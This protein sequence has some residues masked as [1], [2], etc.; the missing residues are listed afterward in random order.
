VRVN[1]NVIRK[2]F[3]TEGY[4]SVLGSSEMQLA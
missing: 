2:L 3:I 1:I 4:N